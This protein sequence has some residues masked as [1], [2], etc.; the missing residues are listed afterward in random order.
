MLHSYRHEGKNS[1]Q[2]TLAAPP[3]ATSR[4]CFADIDVDLGNPLQDVAGTV[5]H[6][7]ELV[8]PGRTDHLA[9]RKKLAD[10]RARDF[11]Y[12]KVQRA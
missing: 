12:Y 8:D 3:S 11:L 6:L 9:L 4:P 5:I 10:G 7:G 2:M 1:L